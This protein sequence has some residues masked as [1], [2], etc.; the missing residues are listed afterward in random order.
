MM[1]KSATFITIFRVKKCYFHDDMQKKNVSNYT[2][3]KLDK[4]AVVIVNI[5]RARGPPEVD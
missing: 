4:M 3:V 1:Q 2:K 5:Y